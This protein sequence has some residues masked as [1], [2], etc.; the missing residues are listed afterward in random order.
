MSLSL[1]GR[2]TLA[3]ISDTFLARIESVNKGIKLHSSDIRG[4]NYGDKVAHRK[5]LEWQVTNQAEHQWNMYN[6][7]NSSVL[8]KKGD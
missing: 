1:E 3:Y 7:N 2:R 6:N 8:F 4:T 5:I